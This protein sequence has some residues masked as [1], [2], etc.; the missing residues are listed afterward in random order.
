VNTLTQVV[1]A[2]PNITMDSLLDG[3]RGRE[4]PTICIGII[5]FMRVPAT[6]TILTLVGYRILSVGELQGTQSPK[7]E[8]GPTK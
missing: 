2:G 8:I 6:R 7:L 4:V 3:M 1:H 5:A